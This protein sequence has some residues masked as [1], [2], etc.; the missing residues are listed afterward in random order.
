MCVGLAGSFVNVVSRY[1]ELH[2]CSI[3]QSM[4][5]SRIPKDYI[6]N[7]TARHEPH[8]KHRAALYYLPGPKHGA[9]PRL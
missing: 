2:A 5:E 7:K 4:S 6:P 3:Y 9:F 8:E 1:D